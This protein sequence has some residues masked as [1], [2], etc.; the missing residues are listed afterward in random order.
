MDEPKRPLVMAD[1][2]NLLTMTKE[3][4]RQTLEEYRAFVNEQKGR[5]EEQA[6]DIPIRFVFPIGDQFA[7]GMVQLNQDMQGNKKRNVHVISQQITD[8]NPDT[9]K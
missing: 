9:Q 5:A 4:Q 1:E 3:E 7:K 6:N 2:F 8:R